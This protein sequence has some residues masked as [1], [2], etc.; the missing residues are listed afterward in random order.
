MGELTHCHG[1]G[2]LRYP[3]CAPREWYRDSHPEFLRSLCVIPPKVHDSSIRLSLGGSVVFAV[4]CGDPAAKSPHL[5]PEK[6]GRQGGSEE[7]AEQE[8][9][10]DLVARL[11]ERSGK[12]LEEILPPPCCLKRIVSLPPLPCPLVAG[13]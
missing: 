10:T 5:Q 8:V 1:D 7:D 3:L 12:V 9:Q 13:Y 11:F 6:Q 2:T 4:Q